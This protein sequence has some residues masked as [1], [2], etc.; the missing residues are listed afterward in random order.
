M[1]IFEFSGAPISKKRHRTFVRGKHV[2][3]YDPQHAEKN[4]VK[5]LMEHNLKKAFNSTNKVTVLEASEL[6]THQCYDI[7]LTFFLPISKSKNERF[8]LW[9]S[10]HKTK[11]DLDNLAKFYLDCANGI[12]WKDDSQISSLNLKKFYSTK[13]KTVMKI[14]GV[15][16]PNLNKS[17][18]KALESFSP[19][20]M[21]DIC[22]RAKEYYE[23]CIMVKADFSEYNQS[24]Q[25]TPERAANLILYIAEAY[26]DRLKKLK[27]TKCKAALQEKKNENIP[28]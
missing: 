2:Q 21:F 9:L 25:N 14:N 19:E 27:T 24:I 18:Q 17:Q 13:P 28:D 22:S 15:K 10:N 5:F 11:P 16:K 3:T 20:E 8:L 12:L 26:G 4:H 6:I 1:M 7:E 23:D